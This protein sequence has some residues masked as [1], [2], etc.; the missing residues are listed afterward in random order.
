MALRL[1]LFSSMRNVV[2][3]AELRWDA[4][5]RDAQQLWQA[6]CGRYPELKPLGASRGVAVNHRHVALDHVLREG[7]EVAFFPPVSGG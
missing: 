7:D 4:P 5:C 6:L 1:K 3:T 2:G